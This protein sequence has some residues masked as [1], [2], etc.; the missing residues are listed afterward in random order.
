MMKKKLRFTIEKVKKAPGGKVLIA[1]WANRAMKQGQAVVDRGKEHIP[2][3]EWKIAEWLENPIIF[4]NHNRD[5]PIGKGIPEKCKVL[6]DGLWIEA[7]I[8]N[9]EA[10]DIK[11]A[12]DLIE[13]EILKTF[14][15]GIDVD[16]EEQAEDG[17]I[18]LKGVNLL[19]TSVVSIPMNQ[20]SFFSIS[21]KSLEETPYEKVASDICN[22]KGAWVAGAIHNRIFELQS[23]DGDEFKRADALQM[24][25]EQA[26]IPTS[27]LFEILAGNTVGIDEEVLAAFAEVL[28]MEVIILTE[29]NEAD[30]AASARDESTRPTDP[31]EEEEPEE[32]EPPKQEK[33]DDS[34]EEPEPEDEAKP[35]PKPEDK[36]D[37]TPEDEENEAEKQDEEDE[38]ESPLVTQSLIFSKSRFESADKAKGWATE[39]SYNADNVEESEDAFRL[40]QRDPN[41]FEENSFKTIELTDGVKAVKGY[42]IKAAQFIDTVKAG[43]AAGKDRATSIAEALKEFNG[44][45]TGK[46]W[47]DLFAAIDIKEFPPEE[48]TPPEE[49]PPEEEAPPKEEAPG[50]NK[51][52]DGGP[53]EPLPIADQSDIDLGQPAIQAAQ[54]Q[55]ELLGQIAVM[56]GQ[57]ISE[58]RKLQAQMASFKPGGTTAITQPNMEFSAKPENKRVL[59]RIASYQQNIDERLK[60]FGV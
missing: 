57:L 58:T 47:G 2:A 36:P 59:D 51:P 20:E 18:V 53:T 41:E 56:M 30:I 32:E 14:S 16:E 52:T 46:D 44:V 28:G 27:E 26:G 11:K 19:E 22:S 39:N 35:E 60:A 45:P 38:T 43:L 25:A 1:G 34:E 12:R 21:K 15:V 48:E 42:L 13:E 6:E 55:V 5:I 54:R 33:A 40:T 31:I 17:T 3:G 8:S 24:V 29:L 23:E 7:E 49:K 10:P 37:P 4:F 9:S 50:V